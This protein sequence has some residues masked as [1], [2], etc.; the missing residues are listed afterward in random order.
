MQSTIH[1]QDQALYEFERLWLQRNHDSRPPDFEALFLEIEFSFHY[2]FD[3]VE[4]SPFPFAISH[5]FDVIFDCTLLILSRWRGLF[6]A[7]F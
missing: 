1:K 4:L 2:R 6:Y 5:D 7:S 3:A